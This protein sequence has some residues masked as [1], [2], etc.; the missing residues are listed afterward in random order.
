MPAYTITNTAGSP[1]ATIGVATTTGTTFPIELIGQGISPYGPI[2]A[3]T[4]YRLLENFTN[5]TPPTNPV[6]GMF[7]YDPANGG[8]DVMSYYNGTIWVPLSGPTTSSS[9]LFNML[10]TA[11]NI[12]LTLTGITPLF[13][14]PNDGSQWHTTGLLLK[15]NGTPS[16][17]APALANLLISSSEDVLENVSISLPTADVHAYYVVQGTT[18]VATNGATVNLEVTSPAT[19]GSLEVDAYLFGFKS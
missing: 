16:A 3:S 18:A 19:G 6:T 13:T 8:T 17:N 7:W 14:D 15:V 12:D 11:T 2:V 9:S 10:P 4:Q 1:V 5:V